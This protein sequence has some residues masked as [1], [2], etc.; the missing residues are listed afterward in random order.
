[1]NHAF[2]LKHVAGVSDI[3]A[4]NSGVQLRGGNLYISG[5]ARVYDTMG[6]LVRNVRG[7]SGEAVNLRPGVY[8]VNGSK[9]RIY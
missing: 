1:M 8:I 5:D 6:R 2:L 9:V 7:A 3:N 4:D